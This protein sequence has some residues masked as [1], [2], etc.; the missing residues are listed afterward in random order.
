MMLYLITIIMHAMDGW[1]STYPEELYCEE[2]AI[3]LETQHSIKLTDDEPPPAA[4]FFFLTLTSFSPVPVF[5][6][7]IFAAGRSTA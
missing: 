2:N 1:F 3:T 7:S 4:G 5:F 6:L